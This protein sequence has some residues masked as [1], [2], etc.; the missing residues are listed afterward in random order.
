MHV[1]YTELGSGMMAC[2]RT[3][4]LIVEQADE[5]STTPYSIY[6]S[7]VSRD[8]QTI[9]PPMLLPGQP[10]STRAAMGITICADS[11]SETAGILSYISDRGSGVPHEPFLEMTHDG[12]QTWGPCVSLSGG[13]RVIPSMYV[14]YPALFCGGKL[15]MAFWIQYDSSGSY[16]SSAAMRFSANHGRDWYPVQLAV[17]SA[18]DEEFCRGTFY[19]NQAQLIWTEMRNGNVGTIDFRTVNGTISP[20]TTSPV[21]SYAAQLPDEIAQGS[22]VQFVATASDNDSLPYV[23]VVLRRQGEADSLVIT[24]SERVPPNGF[25]GTWIVPIDTALWH[26][27]YRAE[28]M[29]ENVSIFP[30]SG[31]WSFH[32]TGWSAARD[33]V[34]HPSSFSVQV[35]P[36]PSNGWPS[37]QL[38]PDWFSHG[39]VRI[40]VYNLLGQKVWETVMGSANADM[41]SH[42]PT[43]ETSGVYLLK[44]LNKEHSALRKVVL[45]R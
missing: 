23:Q 25:R 33:F 3:H 9:T 19:G 1:V 8:G 29:W 27:Y 39:P 43:T 45:M 7:S 14:R 18:Y 44:V 38:T 36:N 5:N 24:L 17:D 40:K 16:N 22:A 42:V 15:W 13:E 2:T 30:D 35:F 4:L 31:A 34:V 32:T 6:C 20:D 12:G 10:D 37:I 11:T 28:D 41:S 26:Y 21:L